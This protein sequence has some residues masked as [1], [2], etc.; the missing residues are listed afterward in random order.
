MR[1]FPPSCWTGNAK[2]PAGSPAAGEQQRLDRFQPLRRILLG[3]GTSRGAA[4]DSSAGFNADVPAAIAKNRVQPQKE[5]VAVSV[6]DKVN[7]TSFGNGTVL[8]LEGAGDKTV[9]KVKF[10]VGEKRLL[11]RYAPL[12]KLDA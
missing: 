10:S 1:K 4:A 6:G 7:H 12:T 5:I 11:L 9:A 8:A 3:A 2:A